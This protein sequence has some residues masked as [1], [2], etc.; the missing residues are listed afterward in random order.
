MTA[1]RTLHVM[2][3][4]GPGHVYR[5]YAPFSARS[6]CPYCLSEG[7]VVSERNERGRAR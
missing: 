1:D 6:F 3:C 4:S 7:A 5:D 2:R